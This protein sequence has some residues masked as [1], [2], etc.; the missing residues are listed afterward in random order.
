MCPYFCSHMWL[1]T[2]CVPRN[3]PLRLTA[4]VRSPILFSDL[5][6]GVVDCDPCVV[7]KDVHFTEGVKRLGDHGIN[8]RF[9]LD[10]GFDGECTSAELPSTS[11]ATAVISVS[12]RAARTM[13][14]PSLANAKAVK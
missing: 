11:S 3:T 10:I 1:K 4:I 6:N 14:A 13:S 9:Q 2:A 7:D 12:V 8:I 5:R